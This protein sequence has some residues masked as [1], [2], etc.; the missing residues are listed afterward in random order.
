EPPL[1]QKQPTKNP[2]QAS[3]FKRNAKNPGS[4]APFSKNTATKHQYLAATFQKQP[5]KNPARA[6]KPQVF[7]FLGQLEPPN[8]TVRRLRH[9]LE[10][11]KNATTKKQGSPK[12]AWPA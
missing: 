11:E 1:F 7:T 8:K 12:R 9:Q 3:F 4:S 10:P 6:Q 2:A 5:T